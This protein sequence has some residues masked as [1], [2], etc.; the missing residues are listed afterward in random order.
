MI[1][2]RLVLAGLTG[3]AFNH[4]FQQVA[5]AA[6]NASAPLNAVDYGLQPGSTQDQTAK[7][8][9]LLESASAKGNQVF[10]PAGTYI[11]SAVLC[12]SY[13]NILGVT[14][15]SR[16]VYAG[17]S[18][19]VQASDSKL[20]QFT[21][22]VFDGNGKELGDK[23]KGLIEANNVSTLLIRDCVIVGSA[24]NGLSLFQSGGA[25]DGNRISGAAD[26]AIFAANSAGLAITGNTISDCGNGGILVHRY[27]K[28]RDGTIISGNRVQKIRADS[29]GTGQNGNGINVY[30]ADN[31]IVADNV[32]SDCAFTAV[33]GNSAGNIQITGNNCTTSGETAIYSEFA[34]EGAIIANNIVDGAANGISIVNFDDGGRLGTCTGNI[35][36]NLSVKGPYAGTF[37]IGISAE[38]DSTITGNLVEGAPTYGL[39]LGWGP[40]MRNLVASGNIVRNSGEG[41]YVTVVDGV[42]PAIITDNIIQGATKGAIVGHKWEEVAMKDLTQKGSAY[43]NLVVERN[44]VS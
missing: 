29:G 44:I 41:I 34:F 4:G 18:G 20:I 14:G 7:F 3:V 8:N 35:V 1:S 36:R 23:V 11:V 30:K 13:V 39:Q 5:Q 32:V 22:L 12:P 6:S 28:G 31:V 25:I 38:A 37:G 10:L 19:F 2:R 42:G 24:Q 27:D 43:P 16:I 40:Y 17:K 21:G 15:Q 26:A 9:A 33:R